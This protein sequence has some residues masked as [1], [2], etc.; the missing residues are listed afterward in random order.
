MNAQDNYIT[1]TIVQGIDCAESWTNSLSLS[2]CH[3]ILAEQ[4]Y[5]FYYKSQD[6]FDGIMTC[7]IKANHC[8]LNDVVFI[9]PA[10]GSKYLW[11]G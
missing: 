7:H 6:R 8:H 9:V 3:I 2:T 5:N 4:Y 1:D 10:S 11:L